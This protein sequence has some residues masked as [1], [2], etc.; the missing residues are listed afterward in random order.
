MQALDDVKTAFRLWKENFMLFV[1][2]MIGIAVIFGIVILLIAIPTAI[3]LSLVYGGDV[4]G[5]LVI[6]ATFWIPILEGNIEVVIT[7]TFLLIILA[8]IIV[9][10]WIFG[11]VYGVSKEIVLGKKLSIS[12]AFKLLRRKLIVLLLT[13][14][15]LGIIAIG[16]TLFI[17][18]G[19]Y[20]GVNF[21][22]LF[23]YDW[24]LGIF[25]CFWY[26]LAI[27][28]T[29]LFVPAIVD[30]MS[31]GAGLKHS[32]KLFKRF[33]LRILSVEF[34]FLIPMALLFGPLPSYAV[35]N[36]AFNP[37]IDIIAS[38]TLAFAALGVFILGLV[39]LPVFYLTMT[40]I[41]QDLKLE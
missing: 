13:G 32:L 17:S 41:Y 20:N 12:S 15:L 26:F 19:F 16:P 35:A 40:K 1:L 22:V 37:T 7:W 10:T 39:L 29:A 34:I 31:I 5:I 24:I 3:L 36:Q 30:D 33:P 11:A 8:V 27:G 14:I 25:S 21:D 38:I 6:L 18:A 23:P 28:L 9:Y 2:T 4:V